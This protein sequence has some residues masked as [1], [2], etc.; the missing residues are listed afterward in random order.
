MPNKVLYLIPKTEKNNLKVAFFLFIIISCLEFI[1][2]GSIIPFVSFSLDNTLDNKFVSWMNE[3]DFEPDTIKNIFT[4]GIFILF[5]TKN[6]F[7]AFSNYY[8]NLT[9]L[10]IQAKL[11]EMVLDKISKMRLFEFINNDKSTYLSMVQHWTGH[12]QGTLSAYLKI[13]FSIAILIAISS[14]VIINQPET[15]IFIIG[16]FIISIIIY[17]TILRRSLKKLGG[18]ENL[19]QA[20]IIENVTNCLDS[21]IEQ[22]VYN[23]S[24]FFIQKVRHILNKNAYIKAKIG[25]ISSSPRYF[26]EIIAILFLVYLL[27]SNIAE[28][29]K[30]ASSLLGLSVLMLVASFK[31]LPIIT[32]L[33]RSFSS[34]RHS[35]LAIDDLYELLKNKNNLDRQVT[36]DSRI[37]NSIDLKVK[38]LFFSS[39]KHMSNLYYE[40]FFSVKTGECVAIIGG[41]GAGKT[42][43]IEMIIGLFPYTSGTITYNGI[44]IKNLLHKKI[45]VS[46]AKQNPFIFNT[47]LNK[48]ITLSDNYDLKKLKESISYASITDDLVTTDDLIK[49]SNRSGGEKQ[50]VG[51]AR[52]FYHNANIIFL[53]EPFSAL[54]SMT[55]SNIFNTLTELKKLHKTL[56]IITHIHYDNPI[57]D[58]VYEITT[59]KIIKIKN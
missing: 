48:N 7:V 22:R 59:N 1:S 27:N 56:I 23:S 5:L 35:Q 34:I 25:L 32:E 18:D 20:S 14:L 49:F 55:T 2:L 12:Y 58:K 26:L 3:Y 54:D 13:M 28:T 51:L 45:K 24:I 10:K 33:L 50:R 19:V 41:S 43:F 4:Y 11:R 39:S 15:A 44:N 31:A 57:F 40:G 9:T 29:P 16:L 38:N 37:D 53:D 47:T 30:Q 52:A 21:Q 36:V 17:Y 42:K 8:V 46:Y 6:I